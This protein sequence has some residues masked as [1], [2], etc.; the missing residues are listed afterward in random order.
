MEQ[1]DWRSV[2]DGSDQQQRILENLAGLRPKRFVLAVAE[3]LRREMGSLQARELWME[4]F[5]SPLPSVSVTCT[6]AEQEV[7]RQAMGR[8]R[9]RFLAALGLVEAF[10]DELPWNDENDREERDIALDR[11]AHDDKVL[12]EARHTKNRTLLK[13]NRAKAL[14]DKQAAEASR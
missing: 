5:S 4:T 14:A 9:D 6:D 7:V 10:T 2:P 13:R 3:V 8:D 12:E 1:M 11:E